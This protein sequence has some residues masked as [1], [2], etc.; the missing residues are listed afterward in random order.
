[1]FRSEIWFGVL[2][3][4]FAMVKNGSS[5]NNGQTST[6]P[7][8]PGP[9]ETSTQK[10]PKPLQTRWANQYLKKR[11]STVLG[12]KTNLGPVGQTST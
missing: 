1:M 2:V 5:K 8:M 10:N 4:F 6:K 7:K 9:L 11:I 12:K 3:I